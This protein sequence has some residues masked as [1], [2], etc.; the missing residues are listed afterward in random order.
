MRWI[1]SV[2]LTTA[3]C[4]GFT[5]PEA[6]VTIEQGVYGLTISG[7]DT[8]DCHDEPAANVL[9]VTHTEVGLHD[10]NATSDRG[11]F[12]QIALDP[13]DHRICVRFPETGN[14]DLTCEPFGVPAGERLRF[15]WVSGPGGG[16]WCAD[17][18]DRR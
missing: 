12:F 10:A 6:Q 4:D 3:A 16:N 13:G 9:V 11:G 15:D 14:R 5:D 8:S 1:L 7:C 18:C 17:G 2:V